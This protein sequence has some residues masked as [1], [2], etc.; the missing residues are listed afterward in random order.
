MTAPLGSVIDTIVLLN[1]DLMWAWP[2]AMFF[3][4][5]RRGLR[6]A[7][8]GV[9][10]RFLSWRFSDHRV[11]RPRSVAPSADPAGAGGYLRPAFFLPATVRFGPLRVRAL[12]LVR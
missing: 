7:A 5:L 8:L 4:S 12:V 9:A 1:V 11:R 10:M 2:T 3:F 6:A